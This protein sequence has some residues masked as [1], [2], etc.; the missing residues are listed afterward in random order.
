MRPHAFLLGLSAWLLAAPA[1]AQCP[2]D[3]RSGD[4]AD[5]V[6][7]GDSVAH[8]NADEALA[9]YQQ[10]AAIDPTDAIWWKVALAFQRKEDWAG[11]ADACA[12][13]EAAA[14]QRDHKKT[15]ADY[16]YR[17]G[18]ALAQLAA[19]GGSWEQARAR[20]L[21]AVE[22]D[23]RYAEAHTE[24]GIVLRNLDDEAGAVQSWTRAIM[25][26]PRA[27]AAYVML[28]DEYQ[29]LMLF[30]QAMQVLNAGLS[31]AEPGDTQLVPLHS[32]LG[33][34]YESKHDVARS[35]T[36]YETAKASCK[37]VA[38]YGSTYFQLGAA[39]AQLTPPRKSEAIQQLQSFFKVV[40]KS[41]AAAKHA[42]QCMQAV[43]IVKR[44]GGMLQ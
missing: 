16:Y 42:D 44:L 30:D 21:T 18:Y 12:K 15:H 7:Q 29:R 35:V 24:L 1:P 28:A 41:A 31:F 23:P 34:V 38:C 43:D 4:A 20:L 13:A 10:A 27:T 40:C 36:E 22:I 6:R 17:H 37:D 8:V 33:L 5:L 11:E 32:L 26:A 39:Y 2:D 9:K 3:P 14:E 19:Q 25:A